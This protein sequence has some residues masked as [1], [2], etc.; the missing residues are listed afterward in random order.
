MA[1]K[2]KTQKQS[3]ADVMG[4]KLLQSDIFNFIFGLLLFFCSVWLVVAFVSYFG[5]AP[6]DQSLVGEL[7]PGDMLNVDRD[8][9]NVCGPL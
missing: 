1:K 4:L 5:T 8:F 3:F 6:F 9:Q 2:K 7:R